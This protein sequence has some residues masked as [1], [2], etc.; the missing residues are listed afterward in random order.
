MRVMRIWYETV[1]EP[2]ISGNKAE[3]GLI[4]DDFVCHKNSDL[5][6]SMKQDNT[7]RILIPPHYTAVLQPC[8]VGINK[9][10]KGLLKKK[11]LIGEDVSMQCCLLDKNN[12]PE[13]R[14]NR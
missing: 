14:G 2:Y 10:L 12:E 9:S 5:M 11:L 7:I 13:S 6:E 8:D 1:Y 4:L 3:S